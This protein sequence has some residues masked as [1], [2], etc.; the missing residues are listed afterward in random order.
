MF[1][2]TF[3]TIPAQYAYAGYAVRKSTSV[4][5]TMVDDKLVFDVFTYVY[6]DNYL[7]MFFL[8]D[9]GKYKSADYNIE[10]DAFDGQAIMSKH[11]YR[12]LEYK[13]EDYE[14]FDK[15]QIVGV[16]GL[17]TMEELMKIIDDYSAEIGSNEM[18]MQA[19]LDIKKAYTGMEIMGAINKFNKINA[20]KK[21]MITVPPIVYG[22]DDTYKSII[23]D[24][25]D[26]FDFLS[27]KTP[28]KIIRELKKLDDKT[29]GVG[30]IKEEEEVEVL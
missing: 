17:R 27:N 8:M 30:N 25:L 15:E 24:E 26:F 29:D 5:S 10:V 9:S 4:I 6:I 18:R 7:S 20:W 11:L 23:G 14:L 3:K 1:G 19:M 12:G 21:N 22:P 13:Q 28:D 2:Y 16:F